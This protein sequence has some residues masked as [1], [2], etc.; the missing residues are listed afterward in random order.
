MRAPGLELRLAYRPPFA[1]ERLLSFLAARSVQGVES[2]DGN[3]FTR[4]IRTPGG[5][6]ATIHLTAAPGDSIVRLRVG[7]VN[8]D[9][10]ALAG[11]LQAA[12]RLF[13]LDAD[14]EAIDEVLAADRVLGSLAREAP[15]TRLPGAV[16]GF[17]L[18]VR[19]I[20]GQQVSVEG[21]RTT[22][23]RIV[24]RLGESLASPAVPITRLFPSAEMIASASRE[25][26]G[27]P[28]ARADAI[29]EL[30]RRVAAGRLDLSGGADLRETREALRS[31]DGIGDWTVEYIAM[32][33]LRDPDAFPA[34]DLG[35]R[36]GFAALGLPDDPRSVRE[37]AE[38]WRPWRAY[39]T[40][41]LWHGQR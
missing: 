27:M 16:D 25:D 19:A 3:S 39:A 38:R 4:S 22:L 10:P 21:A 1:S 5:E 29:L 8:A 20:A 30:G 24:A 40:M 9:G 14:P 31:I 32:R 33:A 23:G 41:L 37:R 11:V 18:A 2:V 17:E 35:V 6:A 28:A 15:G 26:L 13:D 36:R 34:S 12:R 7:G